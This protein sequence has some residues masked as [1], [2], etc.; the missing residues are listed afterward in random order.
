MDSLAEQ[1]L[2]NQSNQQSDLNL[3]RRIVLKK[4]PESN[5]TDPTKNGD[6]N[7]HVT[8]PNETALNGKLKN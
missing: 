6:N 2:V 1:Q 7:N 8:T 4:K 3:H 5:D